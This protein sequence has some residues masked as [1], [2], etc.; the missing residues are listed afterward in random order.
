MQVVL[1][2][3]PLVEGLR[4]AEPLL[5]PRAPEPLREHVLLRAGGQGCTLLAGD[6]AV[7]LW[8]RLDAEVR[9][10]GAALVPGRRLLA[11]LR[12]AEAETLQV[13]AAPG[14]AVRLLAA[15]LVC[16]LVGGDPA[17]FPELGPF[18]T[19]A[20]ALLEPG[21]LRRALRR[22]LFAAAP[23]PGHSRRYLLEAVLCEVDGDRLRLAASDNRRLAVAEAPLL[24]P[25]GPGPPSRMLLAVPALALLGR[26]LRDP[27]GGDPVRASF[28]PPRAY[29][30][31]GRA[32]L[33]ACRLRGRY[34]A[35]RAALPAPGGPAAELPVGPLLAGVRQ[36]AVLREP[37]RALLLLRLGPG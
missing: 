6:G 26:L 23:G 19:R 12:Q 17:G 8:L 34:P 5:P 10:P 2:R 7:A 20:D 11:L 24:P 25:A 18:P 31:V 33:A 37:T 16:E 3:A 1:P 35:W 21:P 22:T 27:D 28:G 9:R 32:T 13:E 15:G 30:R 36:A 14:G 4:L 29:F